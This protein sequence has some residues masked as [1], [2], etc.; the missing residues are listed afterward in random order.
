MDGDNYK[1]SE[2]YRKVVK[3]ND[4]LFQLNERLKKGLRNANLKIVEI[5]E[6]YR[7]K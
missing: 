6:K 4:S 7:S 3:Q 1:L 5:K 2:K